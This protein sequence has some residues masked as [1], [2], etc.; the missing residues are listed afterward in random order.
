[1]TKIATPGHCLCDSDRYV[2]ELVRVRR[3]DR[4]QV[5]KHV[6]VVQWDP[7]AVDLRA[8]G[9]LQFYFVAPDHFVSER[10]VE[11]LALGSL[12]YT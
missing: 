7:V 1:M 12:V 11:L 2:F 8:G 4:T 10:T 5:F 9:L 6:D 3:E